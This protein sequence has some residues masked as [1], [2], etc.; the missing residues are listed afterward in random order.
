M[1]HGLSLFK[2]GED[3]LRLERNPEMGR[4][5]TC[6]CD[7]GFTEI[8]WGRKAREFIKMMVR[9]MEENWGD[10]IEHA[11][12]FVTTTIS[13]NSDNED[14]DADADTELPNARAVIDLDWYV[15]QF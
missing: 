12:P 8:L 13:V 1:E 11:A 9:L 7:I 4:P 2:N 3:T 5:S 6:I 15:V 10:I 14:D